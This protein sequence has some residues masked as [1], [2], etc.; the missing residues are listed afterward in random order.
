[1]EGDA[2]INRRQARAT[3]GKP[4]VRTTVSPQPELT[5]TSTGK[6]S[7]PLTSA[8]ALP[9]A[10]ADKAADK[11]QASMGGCWVNA[12]RHRGFSCVR[13]KTQTCSS[14]QRPLC[15]KHGDHTICGS[16]SQ[17]E[18]ARLHRPTLPRQEL[19]HGR[20]D[21]ARSGFG[22]PCRGEFPFYRRR[23]CHV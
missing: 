6:G 1:M 8:V 23:P 17:T 19:G 15:F 13:R 11:T 22:L 12:E 4:A 3:S 9:G 18:S 2:L 20:G 21:G 10:M 5:S 16:R 7:M 14:S